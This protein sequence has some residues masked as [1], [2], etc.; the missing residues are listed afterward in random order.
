V[1]AE[2]RWVGKNVAR[3]DAFE[4]ATGSAKFASDMF[5][6]NLLYVFTLRSKYP[7]AIIRRIDVSKAVKMPGVVG[8]YTHRDIPNNRFGVFYKDRPVLCDDR[9]RYIGDPVALVAAESREEGQEALEAIEVVYEPLPVVTDPVKAMAP[10]TIKIHDHGNICRQTRITRGNVEEGLSKSYAVVENTYRTPAQIHAYLETEAGISY[11]DEQ[12]RITVIAGGQSPYRDHHEIV[13]TLNL[14][15]E[16]VRVITP[17][18]GGAFGGKDDISVQIHLAL[19]TMKTGRPARLV[20]TREES[21]ISGPKRHPSIV[22]MRTGASRDGV[23]LANDVEIIYDTGAYAGLGPAVLD[24]AIENCNGPYRIPNIDIKA[25]LVYTNNHFASA[26]RGFGAPQVLFAMEQQ[27]DQ[28]AEKLGLDPIEFRLRNAL[29]RGDVAVFGNKLETSVG[30]VQC[31]EKARQHPLWGERKTAKQERTPP[32]IRRGVG[33][34]A[35]IKGYTLGAL[36]DKGR[37]ALELRIDGGFTVKGSFTEIGQGVV[38]A[39]AQ[40]AAELL[41]TSLDKIEV[42]F[43]DTGTTPDTSVTSASRQMF[44]AGNALKDAVAKMVDRMKSAAKILLRREVQSLMLSEEH[45]ITDTGERLD[46]RVVAS[47]LEESGLGREVV[48][49]F[50]VPRVDPIPG[51]LEI[52]HLFYMF[53]VAL[54]AVEVNTLTGAVDVTHIVNI[55]DVGKVVNPQTLTGQLEGAAAQAAGYA[56]FEDAK[57]EDGFLKTTNLST[58]LIPSIKDVGVI[59]AVPVEDFE[60]AG[61]LGAKG[62]GEIGFIPVAP[63]IANAVYNAVGVRPLTLPMTPERVYWLIK[64]RI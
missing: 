21:T 58:Y 17:H 44:L 19:V 51:S 28:L 10:S 56:L 26:F 45:I 5:P 9:V 15:P 62:I 23:L 42:V 47:V 11:I 13:S 59:E 2:L 12:G 33:V 7:H 54:A 20:W 18:V 50:E 41:H 52:P 14:P 63:A 4:K 57:I 31:L 27:M 34:A 35:A 8:V 55:A 24:V 25:W 32:W 3:R 43:A 40:L 30:I 1:T 60:E 64:R 37:V 39:I 53:G 49:E 29:R 6:E 38:Q 36:P 22:K 46:Y 16:K 48:G 61:P